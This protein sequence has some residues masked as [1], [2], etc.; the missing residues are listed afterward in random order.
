MY[1]VE[2]AF[3]GRIGSEPDHRTSQ[4]GKQWCAFSV[5]IDTGATDRDSPQATQWIPRCIAFGEKAE[6]LRGQLTK[7]DRCYIEG[8]LKLPVAW[9]EPRGG[10]ER[11]ISVEVLV[12]V[13]QPLGQIGQRR[14]KS[15]PRQGAQ[16]ARDGHGATSGARNAATRSCGRAGARRRGSVRR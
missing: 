7:G 5:A 11:R 4:A 14:P 16:D 2:V 3:E 9:Y 8:R 13:V 1:G 6:A 15:T 10:G 12:N